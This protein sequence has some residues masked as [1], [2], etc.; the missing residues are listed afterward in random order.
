M[1]DRL[2]FW[3]GLRIEWSGSEDTQGSLSNGL[4]V[5]FDVLLVLRLG[6]L[7][8]Q[9]LASKVCKRQITKVCKSVF[10]PRGPSG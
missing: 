4:A 3:S 7:L 1:T 5:A 10:E 8:S 9:S 6:P 2:V